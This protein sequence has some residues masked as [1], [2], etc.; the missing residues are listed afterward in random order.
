PIFRRPIW[1]AVHA[2]SRGLLSFLVPKQS[3]GTHTREALLLG[4]GWPA[5]RNFAPVRSQAS[6]W[7]REDP[8]YF[9]GSG[10]ASTIFAS[11]VLRSLAISAESVWAFLPSLVQPGTTLTTRPPLSMRMF[12]GMAF[13]SKVFHSSPLGSASHMNLT[14]F[15]TA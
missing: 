13:V 12:V 1:T 2:R 8:A 5:K 15:L 6:A 9:F 10:L 7:E 3:L 11:S 4:R 14:P